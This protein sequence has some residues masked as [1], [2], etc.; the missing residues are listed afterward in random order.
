MGVTGLELLPGTL[1]ETP[2]PETE[3]TELGTLTDD[4]RILPDD[5]S[6]LIEA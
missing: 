2:V 6:Y 4:L 3:G 1:I 5:L